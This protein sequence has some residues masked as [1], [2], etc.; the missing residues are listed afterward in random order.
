VFL[1]LPKNFDINE[2]F[3]IIAVILNII[4]ISKLP[5]K[6]PRPITPLLILVSISLPK[7]LDHSIGV[8]PYNLYD[9]MDRPN[10]EIFDLILYA[11]YPLFGYLFI[12]I[13]EML[14]PKRW[15][16][17][18]YFIAWNLFAILFEFLLLKIHVF[19]YKGW[20]LIY[21]LPLYLITLLITLGFYKYCVNY[22]IQNPRGEK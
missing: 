10:Y 20:K 18:F 6:L 17:I 7:I 14:K 16:L 22:Y 9:I 11:V 1:Y 13:Y 8:K 21:S 12:Y 2:W 4:V 5:R 3:V 15:I 19:T